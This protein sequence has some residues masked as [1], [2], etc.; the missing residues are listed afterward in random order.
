MA[1]VMAAVRLLDLTRD[2][3]WKFNNVFAFSPLTH[4]LSLSQRMRP[5]SHATDTKAVLRFHVC[6]FIVSLPT[7]MLLFFVIVVAALAIVL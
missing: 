3:I 6:V 4:S 1:I 5:R 2:K 7:V